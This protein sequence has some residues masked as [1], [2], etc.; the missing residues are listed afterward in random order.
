MKKRNI[1]NNA[2]ITN[3]IF[4]QDRSILGYY[5]SFDRER[6]F[7]GWDVLENTSL[8]GVSNG[9]IF[10]TASNNN[11]A[12]SRSSSF[13]P[14]DA[15]E[16]LEV[17]IKYKYDKNR[18]DSEATNGK[19]YFTTTSDLSFTEEKSKDFTVIPDGKWHNYYVNMGPVSS[20]VGFINNLKIVFATN[21]RKGDEIYLKSIKI[22]KQT[23]NICISNCE[24]AT[25]EVLIGENFDTETLNSQ[26]QN[27]SFIDTDTFRTCLITQDP[28]VI[29]NKVLEL[30]T[31]AT[32]P[33]GPSIVRSLSTS[34][35]SGYFSCR[36]RQ[37]DTL[38]NLKLM[39]DFNLDQSAIDIKID[40]DGYIKYSSGGSYISFPVNTAVIANSWNDLF[41]EFSLDTSTFRV[42]LNS[43][44]IGNSLSYRFLG[45]I[46]GI[47]ISSYKGSISS[48]YLDDLILISHLTGIEGCSGIGKRG[49][50]TGNTIT[51]TRLSIESNINDTLLVNINGFG[52]AIVKLPIGNN[53]TIGEVITRLKEAISSY[54]LGG[55]ELV[56]VVF[57][58]GKFKII[59]GTYGFDST[60]SIKKHSNS[61]LYEDLG[62]DSVTTEVGIPQSTTFQFVNTFRA[63][64]F[65]LTGIVNESETRII[66][67][68]PNSSSVEIGT[69][70]SNFIGRKNFIVGSNKTIID[71][72]HRATAAGRIDEIVFHGRLP[73]NPTVKVTGTLG[74][75]NSSNF[76]TGIK[77]LKI[78]SNLLVGDTI[79]IDE[80]GY[81]GNG[82]YAITQI[83]G[84][85]ETLVLEG[86]SLPA[87]ENLNYYIHN[88]PKVK[89]FRQKL[90]GS[91][92]LINEAYIGL[93][94]S[95]LYTRYRDY[96][97]ISV[98]WYLHKGDLIGIYNA[99]KVYTGNDPN[100]VDDSKY[101]LFT[102]DWSE[103]NL[104]YNEVYGQGT[105]G[106]GLHGYSFSTSRIASYDIDLGSSIFLE[107]LVISAESKQ[108]RVP[109]NLIASIN[110]GLSASVTVTGFHTHGVYDAN[111]L[112]NYIEH[113]NR[114]FNVQALT[115][116]IQQAYNGYLGSFE[117]TDSQASYFYIDGDAEFAESV[118][119][120]GEVFGSIEFPEAGPYDYGFTKDYVHDPFDVLFSWNT[121]KYIYKCKIYFKEYP[122]ADA[123]SM[124]YYDPDDLEGDGYYPGFVKIGLGNPVEY[125]KVSLDRLILTSDALGDDDYL[126]RHFNTIYD[127]GYSEINIDNASVAQTL[128]SYPYTI[129]E[130]EFTPVKT[131]SFDFVCYT[132]FSTKIS[133]IELYSYIDSIAALDS[134]IEVY[135]S[136]DGETFFRVNP[137]EVSEDTISFKLGAP[138]RYFRII[139][140]PTHNF[141]IKKIF[142]NTIASKIE[143]IKDSTEEDI[144]LID[145]FSKKGEMSQAEHI[146]INN[147]TGEYADLEISTEVEEEINSI[148][149]KSSLH[150]LEDIQNPEIGPGGILVQDQDISLS[151]SENI[152]INASCYGLE[153]LAEGASYYISDVLD[154]ESDL[155]STHVN[156]AKWQTNYVNFPQGTPANIGLQFPGFTLNSETPPS[157]PALSLPI[158]AELY[159]KWK[160][161][162]DFSSSIGVIYNSL[163]SNSNPMG[164]GI[165]IIDSTGRKI[166]IQKL[167]TYFNNGASN[168][169]SIKYEVV[170]S[171]GAGQILSSV[172]VHTQT[173]SVISGNVD[174]NIEST[175]SVTRIVNETSDFLRLY[176]IDAT[177]GVNKQQWGDSQFFE[178]NLKNL[179]NP[180]VGDLRTVIF[181]KW[182]RSSLFSTGT[183]GPTGTYIKINRFL[184]GGQS[185]YDKTYTWQDPG[186][187]PTSGYLSIDNRQPSLEDLSGL[188][189]VALDL[190]KRYC[191]DI[192][193]NHTFSTS[194]SL[195]N[196]NS[197]QFSNS[198]TADINEVAW[199]NSDRLDS[200]WI[201]FLEKTVPYTQTSG[202]T[203]LE[204]LR[205]YPEITYQASQ[206]IHSGRWKDLSN[207]L[208]DNS[209]STNLSQV[210]YPVIS[211]R[212][213]NIFD[214]RTFSLLNQLGI[215]KLR[216][217]QASQTTWYGNSWF[218]RSASLTDNPN[219]VIWDRWQEYIDAN[220]SSKPSKW[221]SFKNINFNL[222]SPKPEY[223]V[224][225]FL[226]S[227]LGINNDEVGQT[228]DLVDPLEYK[229]WFTVSYETEIN[230]AKIIEE[231]IGNNDYLYGTSELQS[232]YL[233]ESNYKP[234]AC[235]DDDPTT[236]V[237]FYSTSGF[238]WRTFGT[239]VPEISGNSVVIS[240]DGGLL[241]IPTE[242]TTSFS[243]DYIEEPVSSIEIDIPN[244]TVSV[245]NTIE[246]QQLIGADPLANSSWNTFYTE[247]DLATEVDIEDSTSPE[248]IFN[249]GQAL[250]IIFT[251]PIIVSGVRLVLKDLNGVG[252]NSLF[253]VSEFKLNKKLTQDIEPVIELENDSINKVS[254]SR[255]LKVTYKSGY[256]HPIKITSGAAMRFNLDSKWSIQ[257]YFSFFAKSSNTNLLNLQE[258]YIRLGKD[259]LRYYEW[260]LSSFSLV[261][262]RDFN[263]IKLK[264]KE[265][266]QT[267]V[268]SFEEQVENIEFLDSQ[269]DFINGP[270]GFF[271][272]E[273]KPEET[274][275]ED[276]ILWLDLPGITREAFELQGL[277]KT[278]YLNNSEAL[279]YPHAGINMNKGYFE[280]V[281]TPDWNSGGY[282]SNLLKTEAFTIFTLY[283]NQDES[284]S[285]FYSSYT[286]LAIAI[287]TVENKYLFT[288]GFLT[289]ECQYK[290]TKVS[291]SWDSLG[292]SID[293]LANSSIRVWINDTVVS[294][295]YQTWDFKASENSQLFIGSKASQYDVSF[296]TLEIATT[297]F[298]YK[299]I[300]DTFSL[301]GGIENL[302]FSCDSSKVIF[303]EIL[304]L[305]DYI[306]LS[307][308]GI[309]YYSSSNSSLP[310]TLY[311]VMPGEEID[312]WIKT[313]FPSNINT[314]AR[315][316]FLKT[317]WR[318]RV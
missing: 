257:D 270:I 130:K 55:Y 218:T 213:E 124:E 42:V 198:N 192:L 152:A 6:D 132:H 33:T 99:L 126:K 238:I 88:I 240:G 48:L 302:I 28:N 157:A 272:V 249:N 246:L 284:M 79:V 81:S 241:E 128:R 31:T 303:D 245:P 155:F 30:K 84:R 87:A 16:Y 172:T 85:G 37:T 103:G 183:P 5:T 294:N 306:L 67:H 301:N 286:G 25:Q 21:G 273:L 52:D 22:Q 66:E 168:I 109:Y 289:E 314:L 156:I 266:I 119:S 140:D 194:G 86:A 222:F 232:H 91:L 112:L 307:L 41:I 230:I 260:D 95:G 18:D 268:G 253:S 201:M 142:A 34:A 61:T 83:L 211:V 49:S 117:T 101:L 65:D 262:L 74:S 258:S 35:V 59:S 19:L 8:A 134:I 191:L 80:P 180:L 133:E 44:E 23:V 281:I 32:L 114:A 12:I 131:T 276:F 259:S 309:N 252:I 115:D 47:K 205:I 161:L 275:N 189:I 217:G 120:D 227:T 311:N 176:Y 248:Y 113:P 13:S 78:T 196:I 27:F 209:Y 291:V 298:A 111:A 63:P 153:N 308:D 162:G 279:Y 72:L 315:E 40:L 264:F 141:Y 171:Y 167:R 104:V 146:R 220:K 7:L 265:G 285:L 69:S 278:L 138:I 108:E 177:N 223:K 187:V 261:D 71:Y 239:I 160:I 125:D 203:Y 199:G 164:A 94:G 169:G 53:L 11:P 149:L 144:S 26:P 102:G 43:V 250:K 2:T 20:W 219:F 269:V 216:P 317:R 73:G 233:G 143:Y 280:A 225:T 151:V 182:T 97:K 60:V 136:I 274:L 36:F 14:V 313:N 93:Q 105:K 247:T 24:E 110:N 299:V 150:T 129:L 206:Q 282:R 207:V 242:T 215:E 107:E 45:P 163:G 92:E 75:G 202:L 212:L 58:D 9:F 295:F 137:R 70:F 210:D 15:N 178:I 224:S 287:N 195:W 147:T 214:V 288:C 237:E 4:C 77:D 50:I 290:P 57:Q 208:T 254:G 293:S 139:T 17:V 186:I 64:T 310:F 221:F 197:T 89:Q 251:E 62:F 236:F 300:P 121:D 318:V 244:T 1:L 116:G 135:F 98:N 154:T 188:K 255:S 193:Q 166:Y 271:E 145:V 179:I 158:T 296:N 305:K 76:R 181:N 54:N 106:I 312:L 263:K 243:V 38:F 90:D 122:N 185:S 200:R 148:L 256:S 267:G 283:N 174:N 46:E 235:F 204:F 100:R 165:G 51:W 231:T 234:Y 184:F 10:I 228:N 82:S 68:N 316:A 170:D 175:L 277:N 127:V 190:G 118:N 96:H 3:S 39:K 292:L 226:C 297:D 56:E 29:S 173:G 304:S 123:L 159:S 229:N